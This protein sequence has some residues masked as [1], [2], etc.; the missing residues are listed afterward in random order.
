MRLGVRRCNMSGCVKVKITRVQ[1]GRSI[2]YLIV[3]R[4]QAVRVAPCFVDPHCAFSVSVQIEARGGPLKISLQHCSGSIHYF[5]GSGELLP[6]SSSDRPDQ[7][8][9]IHLTGVLVSCGNSRAVRTQLS[10]CA[11]NL[12]SF[13]CVVSSCANSAARSIWQGAGSCRPQG[14]KWLQRGHS[15]QMPAV[16]PIRSCRLCPESDAI[17]W[18]SETTRRAIFGS[19]R[20]VQ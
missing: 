12:S 17:H 16:R 18:G 3:A 1:S 8:P 14:I 2:R 4:S 9:Q 11:S 13:A 10:R 6:P 5:F 15:R 19:R 7:T 20:M